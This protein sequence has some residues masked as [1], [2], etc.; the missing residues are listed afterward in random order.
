MQ[1]LEERVSM[2]LDFPVV[3]LFSWVG[4]LLYLFE[5]E[6]RIP[7]FAARKLTHLSMGCLI[8]SLFLRESSRNSIFAQLG[9]GA[10][11]TG[12]ILL[13]FIRPFRFGQYRDKG[14]ISFNLLVLAFLILGLDF[15]FL[16]PAFIADPL[17][18]IV[19]RN[20]SSA[21]WIGEKTVAGS[22]A[23]LLG[24]LMALFRVE[25]LVTRVS[26]AF[27]CTLLEAI[28]GELDNLVMNIPVFAYYFATTRG[29]V[30]GMLSVV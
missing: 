8:L 5:F 3:V 15:G 23:V 11:A 12:A 20:V 18:A 22:L 7:P 10:I 28:G 25:T 19:G 13:C 17:G 21:K 4:A 1:L 14:I 6:S 24:C 29:V 26:L 9:V 2:G 16:A 27:L 30:H